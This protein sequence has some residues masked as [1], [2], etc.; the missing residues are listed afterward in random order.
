MFRIAC[1]VYA[2]SLIC[3]S[4]GIPLRLALSRVTHTDGGHF[5]STLLMG[6][7]PF[8]LGISIIL[9]F[10]SIVCDNDGGA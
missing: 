8:L 3:A 6:I 7:S 9:F 2:L 1:I 5:S 10:N 4:I